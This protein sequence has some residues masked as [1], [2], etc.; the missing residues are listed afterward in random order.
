MANDE[1]A[2]L[3]GP[4][5][6]V[7]VPRLPPPS[8]KVTLP[9]GTPDPGDTGLIVATRVTDWPNTDGFVDRTTLAVVDA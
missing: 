3:A 4:P 6:K 2:R 1:I 7:T 9:V 8:L 5:D